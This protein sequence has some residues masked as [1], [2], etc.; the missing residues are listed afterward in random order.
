MYDVS[1][2]TYAFNNEV[3][4][5]LR[6][7][8]VNTPYIK[9]HTL[10]IGANTFV[11]ELNAFDLSSSFFTMGNQYD[12]TIET[13]YKSNNK[14]DRSVSFTYQPIFEVSGLYH[15]QIFQ[16]FLNIQLGSFYRNL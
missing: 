2:G 9:N 7:E 13:T 15:Y 4:Y 12:A 3:T 10:K 1:F 5:A 8:S 6:F 14:Y 16:Y 11:S